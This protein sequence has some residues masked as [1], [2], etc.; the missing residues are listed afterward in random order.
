[1][2]PTNHGALVSVAFPSTGERRVCAQIPAGTAKDKD[3]KLAQSSKLTSG[4][5]HESQGGIDLVTRRFADGAPEK[6]VAL[7]V[8]LEAKA[9][10][11]EQMLSSCFEENTGY[12]PMNMQGGSIQMDSRIKV[13]H[14]YE[15]YL[16]RYLIYLS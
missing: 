15:P 12:E 10:V 5:C 9:R 3:E 6:G 8:R 7:Y 13:L 16:L 11:E 4:I 1:M 14:E 2:A